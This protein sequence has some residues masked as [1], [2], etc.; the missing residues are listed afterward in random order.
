[1]N[2]GFSLGDFVTVPTL[3]WQV[4][5]SCKESSDD[6][7]SI[8]GDVAGLHIVL[9]EVEEQLEEHPFDEQR[10]SQLATLVEPC[11][12]VL[13][14]LE[15]LIERYDGLGSKSQRTWDRLKW[16]LEDVSRLKER[17]LTST[18]ILAAF[19]TSLVK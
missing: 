8:A 1:M 13:T 9:K 4:Y 3:A 11:H 10:C 17:L 12:T 2:F 7:K 19:N 16:G 5:K 15:S 14:Q 6:F 18:A